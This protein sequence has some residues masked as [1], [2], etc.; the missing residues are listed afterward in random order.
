MIATL[1]ALL[2]YLT[3]MVFVLGSIAY[4]LI[5]VQTLYTVQIVA[6]LLATSKN[7]NRFFVSLQ[8][9]N[10]SYGQFSSFMGDSA[11]TGT[12]FNKLGFK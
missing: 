1:T 8:N 12:N 3:L 4:K 2:S 11:S 9:L 10:L 7:Y 6:V 5:G